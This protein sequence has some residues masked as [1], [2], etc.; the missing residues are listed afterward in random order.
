MKEMKLNKNNFKFIHTRIS[1]YLSKLI[2]ILN[3]FTYIERIDIH[4][5][6]I[7]PFLLNI[8]SILK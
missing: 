6:K 5:Y 1:A 4:Y 7:I 3:L 8:Y 2:V